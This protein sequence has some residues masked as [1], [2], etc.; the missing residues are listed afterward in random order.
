MDIKTE[1]ATVI[2]LLD[3]VDDLELVLAIRNLLDF[4]LKKKE[5]DPVFTAVLARALQES[6]QG[7]GRFHKAVKRIFAN[8][9]LYESIGCLDA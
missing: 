5:A 4:G 2:S 8:D 9:I 1:K 7:K 6:E 3:Q